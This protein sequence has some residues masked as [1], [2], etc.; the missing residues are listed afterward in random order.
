MILSVTGAVAAQ[1]YTSSILIVEDE[2]RIAAFIE[3]GLRRNGFNT[4]IASDGHSAVQQVLNQKYDLMLLDIGLPGKDGWAVLD[5]IQQQGKTIPTIVVSAR[6]G[7]LL[8]EGFKRGV[9]DYVSKPFK[10]TDLLNSIQ[11]HLT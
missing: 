8:M 6:N 5:E 1:V 10:F 11:L 4:A 3:K 7:N 2:P 9:R